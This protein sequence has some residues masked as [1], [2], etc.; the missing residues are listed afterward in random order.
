M[1]KNIIIRQHQDKIVLSVNGKTIADIIVAKSSRTT[2]V[3]LSIQADLD[4]KIE[5]Q[6]Q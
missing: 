4:V 1:A 6:R 2:S 3:N 5:K